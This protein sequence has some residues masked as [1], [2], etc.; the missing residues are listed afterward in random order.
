MTTLSSELPLIHPVAGIKI[1][2]TCAQIKQTERD[3]FVIF[4]LAPQSTTAAVFTRNAF[5]AAPVTLARHHLASTP[6][7]YLIVNS[8]NANAGTGQQGLQDALQCCEMVAQQ[9]GCSINEVLPFSTGVIGTPLPVGKIHHA[10]PQAWQNLDEQ[11]W[12]QAA[13][14]IMTT[15]TFKK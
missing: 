7:R 2:T 3:D 6:P 15:D 9:S 11:H 12:N 8:G 10:I 14:A 5:C 4:A 13:R 1:G